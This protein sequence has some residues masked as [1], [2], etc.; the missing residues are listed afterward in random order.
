MSSQAPQSP[1][2]FLQIKDLPKNALIEK[3]VYI[4]TGRVKGIDEWGDEFIQNV[5]PSFQ[6]G[7]LKLEH[8]CI[9]RFEVSRFEDGTSCSIIFLKSGFGSE[10]WN[11]QL[12]DLSMQLGSVLSARYFYLPGCTEL[13]DIAS[14]LIFTGNVPPITPIPCRKISS[15]HDDSWDATFCV[16]STVCK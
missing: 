5:L 1:T 4:H 9:L 7:E 2:V 13:L 16:M 15:L 3:Q 6:E 10:P 14:S 8:E 12:L 11:S